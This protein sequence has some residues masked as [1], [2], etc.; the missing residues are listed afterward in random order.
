MTSEIVGVGSGDIEDEENIDLI[1]G[2][3]P[4]SNL[5]ELLS[6]LPPRPEVDRILSLYFSAKWL[7]FR[8]VPFHL[9]TSKSC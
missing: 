3:H 2:V 7:I 9:E 4:A 5:Q 1:L 8:C 6:L